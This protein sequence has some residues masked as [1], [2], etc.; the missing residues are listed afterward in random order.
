MSEV[1]AKPEARDMGGEELDFVLGSLHNW[2]GTQ[3]GRDLYFSDYGKTPGLPYPTARPCCRGRPW[4][5]CE[6]RT[7]TFR[8]TSKEAGSIWN[9]R[10]SEMSE[11]SAKPEARDME[12]AKE[13]L[14]NQIEAQRSGFDLEL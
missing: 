11:V 1:S 3:G 12:L 4:Y 8:I 7:N 2:I 13:R 5:G 14:L 10:R 9:C 6:C